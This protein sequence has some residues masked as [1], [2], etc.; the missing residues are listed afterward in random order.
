MQMARCCGELRRAGVRAMGAAP[1][2]AVSGCWDLRRSNAAAP[3]GQAQLRGRNRMPLQ[4]RCQSLFNYS[5]RGAAVSSTTATKGAGGADGSAEELAAEVTRPNRQQL[6]MLALASALPFVGFGFLDNFLMIIFGEVIDQSLCVAM[7]FSTM[8]AA[9]IGNT[10]SDM[11][12]IFAGGAVEFI[13]TRCGV[14]EPPLSKEQQLMHVT[15][16]WQYN[17]QCI[18]IVIGCTLGCCPLLWLDPKAADNL[19]RQKEQDAMLQ[20]VVNKVRDLLGAEAAS[21][22]FIDAPRKELY[23]KA[24]TENLPR[25]RWTTDRGF[26]GHVFQSG[27]YVNIV[28]VAE[29]P[30][31]VP[32]L[33]DNFMG[34]GI[35]VKNL[36][37]MPIFERGE[38]VGLMVVINK[39][40][41]R[42]DEGFSTKDEDVLSAV[43][44]HASAAMGNSQLEEILD[45]CERAMSKR[46]SPEW[47]ISAKQRKARLYLPALQGISATVGAEATA[48]MLVDNT[49]TSLYPEVVDGDLPMEGTFVGQDPV[50]QAAARGQIT[51]IHYEVP[52]CYTQGCEIHSELC[53][54]LLDT[55][56]KCLGVIRCINKKPDKRFNA[57]DIEYISEVADHLGMML[58]GPDTGLRRVMKVT[59]ARMQQKEAQRDT[60]H[61]QGIWCSLERTEGIQPAEG[62]TMDAYVTFSIVRGDPL[63][64]RQETMGTGII[65][66]RSKDKFRAIRKFTKTR[67]KTMDSANPLWNETVLT[68]VPDD[69]YNVAHNEL[70]VHAVVWHY[71]TLQHDTLVAQASFPLAELGASGVAGQSEPHP[72]QLIPGVPSDH[73]NLDGARIWVSLSRAEVA[74]AGLVRDLSPGKS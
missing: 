5:S 57:G 39:V 61:R 67:T 63:R 20:R 71:H 53:V 49:G 46:G 36:L 27:Q 19:K 1:R 9:A 50:G 30:L 65:R 25:F 72:L 34:S 70:Y 2:P 38:I 14:E 13:A 33:H 6:R 51:N 17:G 74:A 28:D 21:L 37:C 54:P 10:L 47:S 59:R 42:N 56:E 22:C 11:V 48:L 31:Y 44:S 35:R 32:E 29:E 18:G 45:G 41:D 55:N 60:S 23:S 66:A 7:G 62:I 43:C 3:L 58:E 64:S 12:G 69:L 24:T 26:M 40:N 8:A 16:V 15:K 52:Q 73:Y 68:I 4:L